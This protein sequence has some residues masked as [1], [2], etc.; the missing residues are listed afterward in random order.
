MKIENQEKDIDMSCLP[1]MC[2]GIEIITMYITCKL[3]FFGGRSSSN[4]AAIELA[5]MLDARVK[6]KKS[7]HCAGYHEVC[8]Q[9]LEQTFGLINF[10]IITSTTIKMLIPIQDSISSVDSICSMTPFALANLGIFW[11]S[12]G[13]L[14]FLS[15]VYCKL[16]SSLS[17]NFHVLKFRL[18]PKDQQPAG[19][20]NQTGRG[21]RNLNL[22]YCT[23]QFETEGNGQN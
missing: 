8:D 14:H 3:H 11:Q 23:V 17:V 9:D 21:S 6:A 2:R 12:G 5:A 13:V 15:R 16:R 20:Y 4:R 10:L 18:W 19:V 1:Q 7:S 22:S